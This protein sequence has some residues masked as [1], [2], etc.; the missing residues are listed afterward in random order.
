MRFKCDMCHAVLESEGVHDGDEIACPSCGAKIVCH[1]DSTD[2]TR[3]NPH[4]RILSGATGK[5]RG[6]ATTV[7]DGVT[8]ALGVE[9]LRGFQWKSFFSEVFRHHSRHEV[10]DYFM[11]GTSKTTPDIFDVAPEWPKPWMFVRCLLATAVLYAVAYG[12]CSCFGPRLKSNVTDMIIIGS[13]AVPMSFTVLF[14]ELN[15]R[16]NV[17]LFQVI[18]MFFFGG[19]MSIYLIYPMEPVAYFLS[20]SL[21]LSESWGAVLAGPIEETTKLAAVIFLTRKLRYRYILNGLLFGAAVGAGFGVFESSGYAY[22]TISHC[23]NSGILNENQIGILSEQIISRA[24]FAPVGHVVY[25]AISVAAL[26]RVMGDRSFEFAHLKDW[27]F[28]RLFLFSVGLHF[29]WNSPLLIE[30]FGESSWYIKM[31]IVGVVSWLVVLSLV[32][33]G[34]RQIRKEQEAIVNAD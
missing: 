8:S 6:G 10:E 27:R 7:L 34:L 24:I 9:N 14:Y 22:D 20:R 16:R 21:N 5:S 32:Q 29:F 4:V 15:V 13:F 28:L 26:W 2:S 11:V 33:E 25:T 30:S 23:S 12:M 19:I 1:D 17:S 3:E 18:R 31:A